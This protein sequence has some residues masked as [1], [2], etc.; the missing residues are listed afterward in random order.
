[1]IMTS[2]R[3]E[4]LVLLVEPA[5][6]VLVLQDSQEDIVKKVSRENLQGIHFIQNRLQS[7]RS[8]WEQ[9]CENTMILNC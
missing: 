2:V 6:Y 9:K 5:M 7:C 8:A 4:Q 3:M 1:M